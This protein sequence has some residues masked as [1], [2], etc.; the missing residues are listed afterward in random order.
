M[1]NDKIYRGHGKEFQLEDAIFVERAS[2]EL[3]WYTIKCSIHP[4]IEGSLDGCSAQ[5]VRENL[6]GQQYRSS[7]GYIEINEVELLKLSGLILEELTPSACYSFWHND[8]TLSRK[9]IEEYLRA[10]CPDAPGSHL[11]DTRSG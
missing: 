10:T 8:G 11:P 5:Y 6:G 3:Y 7:E 4:D 2:G 9:Q 1:S